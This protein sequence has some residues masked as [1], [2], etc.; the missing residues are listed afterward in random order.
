MWFNRKK[1]EQSAPAVQLT[2]GWIGGGGTEESRRLTETV[3]TR[4]LQ[5]SPRS[6]V[7]TIV[8]GNHG[9]Q[10]TTQNEALISFC[11]QV[12][13]HYSE[14]FKET[15]HH[16]YLYVDG[17]LIA[18]T[19]ATP[20]NANTSDDVKRGYYGLAELNHQILRF[21]RR[22]EEERIRPQREAEEAERQRKQAEQEA[23]EAKKANDILR[24]L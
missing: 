14:G 11:T 7:A 21:V 23:L 5:I 9:Y 18:E 17:E 24:R 15:E 10:V 12:T 2:F 20:N 22:Q 3:I 8:D 19:W 4:A 16:Y 13:S 1:K 6:W